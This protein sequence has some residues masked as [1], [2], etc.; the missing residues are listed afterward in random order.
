[1]HY[2]IADVQRHGEVTVTS[3]RELLETM[4]K[5]V[6]RAADRIAISGLLAGLIVGLSVLSF[7]YRPTGFEGPGRSFLETLLV[8]GVAS[9]A[10]PAFAF[11]RSKR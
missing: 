3:R 10:W 8:F 2:E 11:W 4:I 5:S 6:Q 1:L 7:V 9:G